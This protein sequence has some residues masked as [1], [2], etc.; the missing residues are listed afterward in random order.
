MKILLIFQ[1]KYKYHQYKHINHFIKKNN[2]EEKLY[3]M[4]EKE[5]EQK[6]KKE[7]K[8]KQKLKEEEH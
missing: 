4:K 3:Q 2:K 6:K 1:M 5:K 7:K 8:E